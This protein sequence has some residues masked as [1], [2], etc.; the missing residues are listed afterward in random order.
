MAVEA[1]AIAER[2]SLLPYTVRPTPG[3]A[4]VAAVHHAKI[5]RARWEALARM[6]GW[7]VVP[8]EVRQIAA[9][10]APPPPRPPAPRPAPRPAPPPAPRPAARALELVGGLAP[11]AA[12]DARAIRLARRR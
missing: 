3:D 9:R 11:V 12:A 2:G 5:K 8:V 7:R 10:P 4:K 1:Y 6:F